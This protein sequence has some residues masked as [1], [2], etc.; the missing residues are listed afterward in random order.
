MNRLYRLFHGYQPLGL[1]G[2]CDGKN[3]VS[4]AILAPI[5]IWL[6]LNGWEWAFSPMPASSRPHRCVASISPLILG[7]DEKSSFPGYL[8]GRPVRC[9]PRPAQPKQWRPG[10]GGTFAYSDQ[11]IY[12]IPIK[13]RRLSL[14]S[15]TP[16]IRTTTTPSFLT[17]ATR[18]M[19]TRRRFPPLAPT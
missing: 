6:Y 8:T 4:S 9:A 7:L 17:W 1:F 10:W 16:R 19:K 2:A 15:K 12:S 3:F 5:F 11:K 14:L 13:L 18:K